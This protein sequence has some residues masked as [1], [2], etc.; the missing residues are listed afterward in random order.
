MGDNKKIKMK[1]HILKKILVFFS[2]FAL[3]Q[4]NCQDICS[5]KIVNTLFS[6]NKEYKAVVF[7]RDFGATTGFSTEI[8]IIK[9]D[10][11]LENNGGNIF[12]ADTDSGNAPSAYWGGPDVLVKWQNNDL[13]IKYDSRAYVY[14]DKAVYKDIKIKYDIIK[15]DK[16]Y[17][18]FLSTLLSD[19]N[20]TDL[21]SNKINEILSS[22]KNMMVTHRYIILENGSGNIYKFAENILKSDL[23]DTLKLDYYLNIQPL[24]PNNA[25]MGSVLGYD[26]IKQY[27]KY[28]TEPI[29]E[30][31][32]SIKNESR[33][34]RI[35]SALLDADLIIEE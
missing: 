5:N 10:Q 16:Q 30:M 27:L 13:L 34:R 21:N 19:K 2:F 14:L 29:N 26:I 7:R 15:F 32:A 28:K 11:K 24:Y 33:K 18:D 35:K 9:S 4:I 22:I 6:S 3:M 17:D 25:E 31:L 12:I 20:I 8:S 1:S 23:P